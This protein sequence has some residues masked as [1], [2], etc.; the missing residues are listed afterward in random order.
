M[1]KDMSEHMNDP[2]RPATEKHR[3]LWGRAKGKTLSPYQAGLVKTRLPDVSV[4]I[5]SPL[6]HLTQF[7][8]VRLEI[9]FGGAEHLLHQARK[10]P[11][12]GFI[13]VEPFINGVAKALVGIDRQGHDNIY[14]HAGD[15]W[16]FIKNIPDASLDH[17]D[18]LYPDPWPKKRHHKRRLIR[19]NIIKEFHRIL[20]PNGHVHFASDIPSYVD[21]ALIR[22]LNH[23]GFSWKVNSCSNWL[24]PFTGWIQTRFEARALKQGR[25]P[26]YFVF[27]KK[28]V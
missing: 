18:I 25:T 26:H 8:K 1:G 22:V 5:L 10:H 4:D 20:K 13:G 6:A 14:L 17:I 15:V 23:G 19:T 16:D 28:Q 3:R 7:E 21:W 9:G 27:D 2:M 24:T 11:D 12:I